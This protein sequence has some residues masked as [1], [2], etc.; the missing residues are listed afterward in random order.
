MAA[1]SQLGGMP[2]AGAYLDLAE[3]DLSAVALD[4]AAAGHQRAVVTPLLFTEAFHASVDVPDAVRDASAASGIELVV[5]EILGTG[6][7]MLAVVEQSMRLAGVVADQPLVLVSVG[8][9]SAAANDAVADLAHRLAE[10]RSAPVLPAFG[11]RSPRVAEVLPDLGDQ[12][13][14][15]PL[16]LSPGL[17]LDP[18]ARLAAER[19]LT[20]AE[21]LGILAASLLVDRYRQALVR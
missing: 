11:T 9:S 8:S 4:L 6:D 15:V 1:A 21:P 3:P 19:G 2:T 5:A 7:D 16:F 13:A 14:I 17:L 12:A 20:M 18:L 10:R